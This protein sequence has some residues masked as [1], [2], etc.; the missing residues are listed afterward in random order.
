MALCNLFT[1]CMQVN[2]S[3]IKGTGPD[4]LIVKGDIDDYLGI[5]LIFYM[6]VSVLFTQYSS[7]TCFPIYSSASR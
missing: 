3:S 6:Y 7:N 2:L 4:G 1:S 5:F